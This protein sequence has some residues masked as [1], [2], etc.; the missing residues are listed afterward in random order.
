MAKNKK[1]KTQKMAAAMAIILAVL[2]LGSALVGI[3][4]Y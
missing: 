3:F 4:L 1:N 2:M